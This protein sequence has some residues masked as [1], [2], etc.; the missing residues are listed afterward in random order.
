MPATAKN[1]T[2]G[3]FI[4]HLIF[5]M[6][7]RWSD[8]AGY[9]EA[10]VLTILE[11]FYDTLTHITIPARKA[12]TKIWASSKFRASEKFGNPVLTTAWKCD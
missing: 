4:N 9:Q 10:K 7:R 8:F 1:L 12:T 5:Q 6:I 2:T 3:G 11:F